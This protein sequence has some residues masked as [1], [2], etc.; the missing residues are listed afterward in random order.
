MLNECGIG[1]ITHYIGVHWNTIMQ[2]MV[3]RTIYEA[4]RAGVRGWELAPQQ[5]WWEQQMNLDNEY[6]G[7]CDLV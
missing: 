1:T 7:V 2:Y 5:W 4:C 6:A 3:N